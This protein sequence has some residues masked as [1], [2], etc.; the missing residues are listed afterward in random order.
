MNPSPWDPK[1][2]LLL[3]F[4]LLLTSVSAILF[5]WTRHALTGSW[6]VLYSLCGPALSLFTHM[7]YILFLIQTLLLIL[8]F[9]ALVEA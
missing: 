4:Y 9:R 7:S 5:Y 2:F 1:A 8:T 6:R 3:V